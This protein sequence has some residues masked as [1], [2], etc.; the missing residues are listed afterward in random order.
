MCYLFNHLSPHQTWTELF[1]IHPVFITEVSSSSRGTEDAKFLSFCFFCSNF[2][3]KQLLITLKKSVLLLKSLHFTG[4]IYKAAKIISFHWDQHLGGLEHV[5]MEIF[6]LS[7]KPKW[8][9][10]FLRAEYGWQ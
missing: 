8:L 4:N 1:I 2:G 5:R 6:S 9:P 7:Y 10:A 3:L